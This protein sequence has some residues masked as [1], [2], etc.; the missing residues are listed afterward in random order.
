MGCKSRT[1][2][3]SRA[4]IG[5]GKREDGRPRGL[6]REAKAMSAESSDLRWVA[7]RLDMILDR[8]SGPELQV[9]G[10]VQSQTGE[11]QAFVFQ[12][13]RGQFRA[14]LDLRGH[15]PPGTF[16]AGIGEERLH[17]GLHPYRTGPMS[18]RPPRARP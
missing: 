14:R 11:A 16:Y 17:T 5:A 10:P 6:R 2:P 3:F 9:C 18:N 13:D 4:K 12:D 8:P 7:A 1:I 15:L